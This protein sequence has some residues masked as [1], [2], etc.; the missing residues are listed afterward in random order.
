[1]TVAVIIT[2]LASFLWAITNHID[3][4]AFID[5]IRTERIVG[6]FNDRPYQ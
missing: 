2:L 1:M 5:V 4:N 6:R 3:K